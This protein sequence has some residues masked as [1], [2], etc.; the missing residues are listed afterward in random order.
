MDYACR[1]RVSISKGASRYFRVSACVAMQPK[2]SAPTET[3]MRMN[4]TLG[5][6][7]YYVYPEG[8]FDSI[9]AT[10]VI[11]VERAK[12]IAADAGLHL[13][14]AKQDPEFEK[15]AKKPCPAIDYIN[16]L[17]LAIEVPYGSGQKK[18]AV[19]IATE[20]EKLAPEFAHIMDIDL[21][22]PK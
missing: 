20:L 2:P 16:F 15:W 19:E 7:P 11:L 3:D 14:E 4:R 6:T 13:I 17:W 12:K 21:T 1:F 8:F 9:R 22:G 10:N 5:G 18:R